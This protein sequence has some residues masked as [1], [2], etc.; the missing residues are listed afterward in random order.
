MNSGALLQANDTMLVTASWSRVRTRSVATSLGA[1]WPAR[2]TH[3]SMRFRLSLPPPLRAGER[4]EDVIS[5]C[6]KN[7]VI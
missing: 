3:H 1:P 7:S 5:D 4:S 2:E 6:G